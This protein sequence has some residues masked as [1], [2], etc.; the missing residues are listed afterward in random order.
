MAAALSEDF[1]YRLAT[2]HNLDRP[3]DAAHVLFVGIDAERMADGAKE[4]AHRDWPVLHALAAGISL[5]DDLASLHA[6]AGK[7]YVEC[8]RIVVAAASRVDPRRAA[9]L[10]H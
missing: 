4:I 2:I 8:A 1:L 6:T 10:S 9:E 5:A 7:G 3:A